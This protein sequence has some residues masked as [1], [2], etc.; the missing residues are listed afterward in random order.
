MHQQQAQYILK[1]NSILNPGP[2]AHNGQPPRKIKHVVDHFTKTPTKS[3][4]FGKIHFP[5]T[6][7]SFLG[8]TS[9]ILFDPQT[10]LLSWIQNVGG[11]T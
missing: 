11:P 10:P 7:I 3:E 2:L 4:D 9:F 8:I 5:Q 6:C 1:K